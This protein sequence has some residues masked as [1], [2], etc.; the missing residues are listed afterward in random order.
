MTSTGTVTHTGSSYIVKNKHTEPLELE[1]LSELRW[2]VS[3]IIV[4]EEK[5]SKV[6]H[7]SDLR[8]QRMQVVA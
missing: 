7:V 5:F 1:E 6:Q 3:E 8:R 4:V 2:Q